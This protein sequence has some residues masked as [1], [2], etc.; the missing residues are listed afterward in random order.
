MSVFV[1]SGCVKIAERSSSSSWTGAGPLPI[2]R[3]TPPAAVA[4]R[5]V[6]VPRH[7]TFPNI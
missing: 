3:L 4:V 2:S 5:V 7:S 6:D 1:S